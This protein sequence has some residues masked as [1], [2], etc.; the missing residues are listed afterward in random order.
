[1]AQN[2]LP[3]APQRGFG[4]TM[5]SDSWWMPTLGTFIGL[6]GFAVYMTWAAFQNA[7]F[8]YEG[9]LSPAYSPLL[10]L[11][12]GLSTAEAARAA[13][14]VWIGDKPTWWPAAVPFLPALLIL[15][16]PGGFRVTCYYYRGAYYKA[17][18]ASPPNCAVG[19]PHATY[20]GERAFPL[21]IQNIHR[22]FMYVAVMFLFI[23]SYDAYRG[24]W[25]STPGGGTEFGIGVGTIVLTLNV[26]F[27]SMYTLGCHSLRHVIGGFKDRLSGAPVR[28]QLYKGCSALNKHHMRWA[29]ASLVW[30]GFTDFYVRMCS[31]GV[32]PDI[33]LI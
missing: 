24:M 15:W 3:M 32:W 4:E 22:Y 2:H 11:P 28:K 5:R 29:W 30:V 9:Y 8:T 13:S 10:Y 23:L 1:M 6:G 21:I 20:S 16:G 33:R 14:H 18:W 17:F 12:E 19:K 27:L 31:M 7:H 25:F 26:V